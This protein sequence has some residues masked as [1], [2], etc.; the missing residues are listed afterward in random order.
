MSQ[1]QS[2]SLDSVGHQTP[3]TLCAGNAHSHVT[4]NLAR[5]VYVG[6]NDNII[7]FHANASAVVLYQI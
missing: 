3:R 2:D 7:V 6:A 1:L 4:P 5:H